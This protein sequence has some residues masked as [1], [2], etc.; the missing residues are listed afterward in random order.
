M[1]ES[2]LNAMREKVRSKQYVISF[3]ARKEMLDDDLSVDDVELAIFNG[4]V[5]ERQRDRVTAEWKYR[6]QGESTDGR[7]VVV[8]AKFTPTGKLVAQHRICIMKKKNGKALICDLCGKPGARIRH[9]N[10]THGK[11]KD[12]LLIQ[13]VPMVDCPTCGE[14]YFTAETLHEV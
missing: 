11:G 1:F 13:N 6:L 10:E 3:H 4:E 5:L 7:P 14:A 2:V 8:V 9:I 12:L